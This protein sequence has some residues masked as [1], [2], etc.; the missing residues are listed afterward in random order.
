[1]LVFPGTPEADENS[2][3][4]SLR[5]YLKDL[6]KDASCSCIIPSLRTWGLCGHSELTSPNKQQKRKPFSLSSQL[7]PFK[8]RQVFYND[9]FLFPFQPTVTR[10]AGIYLPTAIFHP[11]IF[12]FSPTACTMTIFPPNQSLACGS[13]WSPHNDVSSF[14]WGQSIK[15]DVRHSLL[16]GNCVHRLWSISQLLPAQ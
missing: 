15:T 13:P 4:L 12:K 3:S 8:H 9:L 11:F 1:M 6:T 2:L 14:R 7:L 5:S 16:P 10:G